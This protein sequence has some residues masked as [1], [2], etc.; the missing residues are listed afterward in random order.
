MAIGLKL[1]QQHLDAKAQSRKEAQRK[2]KAKKA[3]LVVAL[4]CVPLRLCALYVD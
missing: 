3:V 2:A 4:L 1:Q